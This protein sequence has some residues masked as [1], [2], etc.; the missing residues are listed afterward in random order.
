LKTSVIIPSYDPTKKL[1]VTLESLKEQFSFIDELIVIVDNDIYGDFL[2]SLEE[3]Y[4]PVI[5]IKIFPQANAGR[6]RSRNR[7]VELSTGDLIIFLD[8]DM[9]VE[10]RL[11]EK[12]ISYHSKNKGVIVSGNGYR[13]PIDAT[14]HFGKFLIEMEN[15]WKEQSPEIGEITFKAFNFTACNMSLPKI[16]FEQLNGFDPRFKD[17]EDF[18]FAVR[19]INSGIPILYDRSLLAWHNDWPEIDTFIRRQNEYTSA[20]N[21]IAKAHPKYLKHFPNLIT[22]QANSGKKFLAS[23]VRGTI[24]KSV[25]A[26]NR[27]FEALPLSIKFIF[28]RL[29]ISSYSSINR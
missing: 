23:I 28:Y 24:A 20:K 2:K 27:I 13:N 7:G 29:V 10:G 6:A 8:D 22:S 9:L 5:N 25:I 1:S 3:K 14:S 17:G 15:G 26:K 19:A 18:D 12:H 11:I 16:C 4:S 21:E